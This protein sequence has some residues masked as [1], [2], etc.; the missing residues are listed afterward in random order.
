MWKVDNCLNILKREPDGV[1]QRWIFQFPITLTKIINTLS[2]RYQHSS[3]F[4]FYTTFTQFRATEK[5]MRGRYSKGQK[6]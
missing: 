6:Y 2:Y 4:K 5:D 1:F 3:E